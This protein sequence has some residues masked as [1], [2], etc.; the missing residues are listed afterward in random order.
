MA[1]AYFLPPVGLP[2]PPPSMSAIKWQYGRFGVPIGRIDTPS[3]FKSLMNR[4]ESSTKVLVNVATFELQLGLQYWRSKLKL[5][6]DT[7]ADPYNLSS[8]LIDS[9]EM[10]LLDVLQER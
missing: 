4:I 9:T 6:I 2:S 8:L 3:A 5:K 10:Y 7:N 1:I